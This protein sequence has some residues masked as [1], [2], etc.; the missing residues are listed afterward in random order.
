MET[1]PS[2]RHSLCTAGLCIVLLVLFG[3][4]VA[5]ASDRFPIGTPYLFY[6]ENGLEVLLIENHG[7]P[8]IAATAVIRAGS[9]DEAPDLN[10]ATHFL[11]HLLFDG[12]ESRSQQDIEDA[13]DRMG[14]YNNAQTA[15][16]HTAFMILTE[17]AKFAD[18][19][20]LQADM[21]FRSTLPNE[22]LEKEK[23]IILEEM[24]QN[25]SNDLQ[26]LPTLAFDH[27]RWQG[28]PYTY[29]VLGTRE[30]IEAMERERLWDYYRRHYVPD[31]MSLLVMGDFE[32]QEMMDIVETTYGKARPGAQVLHGREMP[33]LA[34]D[35]E[36]VRLLSRD[37]HYLW[38]AFP[39]EPI[40]DG[41]NLE[42]ME[43]LLPEVLDVVVGDTLRALFKGEILSLS[44]SWDVTR[45]GTQLLLEMELS[46]DAIPER[47]LE[48]LRKQM[49]N[50]DPTSASLSL[51]RAK[52]HAAIND[53][54]SNS[55]RFHYFG[56]L[57]AGEIAR[58]GCRALL[59]QVR[60]MVEFR[61]LLEATRI[62][63]PGIMKMVSQAVPLVVI[64]S[65]AP[66]E[67]V[68]TV[69]SYQE[70]DTTLA[71]GL[72]LVVKSESSVPIFAAH[73]LFQER[74]A[75]EEPQRMGWVDMLHRLLEY[76]IS[77]NLSRAELSRKLDSLHLQWKLVDDPSIPFDDYY[78]QPNFSFIRLTG[79]T[80][81][82]RAGLA[83]IGELL[84]NHEIN[85]GDLEAVRN[86][87]LNLIQT[88][89]RSPRIQADVELRKALLG[90]HPLAAAVSGHTSTI[91]AVTSSDLQG[92]R[93]VYFRP[94]HLILSI[95]TNETVNATLAMVQEVFNSWETGESLPEVRMP[96]MPSDSLVRIT[97]G[98]RQAQIRLGALLPS[99]SDNQ[100]HQMELWTGLLS[101]NLQKDLRETRGLA[102]SVGADLVDQD[103]WGWLVLRMGTQSKNI[104][105]VVE[106]MKEWVRKLYEKPLE[107]S[108]L[109]KVYAAQRGAKLMRQMAR[110]QQAFQ[111]GWAAMKRENPFAPLS[112]MEIN[113]ATVSQIARELLGTTLWSQ[114][115]V[116]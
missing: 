62:G 114:V 24:G 29:P 98:A 30:S 115:I 8:M 99:L 6:L 25:V 21:L 31:N 97:V 27:L 88:Q 68:K 66:S 82:Q 74:S 57:H 55:Q 59:A 19:L 109:E 63:N 101:D 53:E 61:D 92:F 67:E 104:P 105:T 34:P 56:M 17:K 112:E 80:A 116:E 100:V 83:L 77:P 89:E 73:F 11:E 4:Q 50:L 49:M 91:S 103:G 10:G 86:E 106:A 51:W 70:I 26:Y 107:K 58:G 69:S 37:G 84:R 81:S 90:D 32:P 93:S 9:G 36:P 3:F 28:T 35:W 71:N 113:P 96:R 12:T 108:Q 22:Q 7:S 78:T 18:A 48:S 85:A 60:E 44:W 79:P 111:L 39:W 76:G 75:F 33:R 65:P 102:Y 43:L 40:R 5:G 72:R 42:S 94:N 110:E 52:A 20:N 14:G 16:D 41:H 46:S 2:K 87:I 64:F 95:V 15:R 45:S 1:Y 47:I 54:I 23:G 38:L 13:F